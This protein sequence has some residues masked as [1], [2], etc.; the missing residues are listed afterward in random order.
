MK[1]MLALVAASFALTACQQGGLSTGFDQSSVCTW[2]DEQEVKQCR[3]GQ[4]GIF[5]PSTFGNEQLPL[6]VTAHYCDWRYPVVHNTGG[7]VCVI[8]LQRAPQAS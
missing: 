3:E 1:K 8:T 2:S 4:L 7:V 5:A 6:L